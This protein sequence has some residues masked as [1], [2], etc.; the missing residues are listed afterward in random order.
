MTE[1]YPEAIRDFSTSADN[2]TVTNTITKYKDLVNRNQV[3]GNERNI[4]YWRK[5][6]WE[7]FSKFVD[8]K[9][10]QK[11]ITQIKRSKVPGKAIT[12]DETNKWLIVIPLD[13]DASCYHGRNTDWCTTKPNA[14]YFEKYFYDKNI[15]LI[16]FLQKETGKRWAIACHRKLDKIEMFD[17]RDNSINVDQ[18]QQQTGLDPMKYKDMALDK[19]HTP[20]YDQS[21]QQYVEALAIIQQATP[22]TKVDPQLEQ[23]LLF[24]KDMSSI[25]EYCAEVKGRWDV[26]ERLCIQNICSIVDYAK[27]VIKGRWPEAE[28]VVLEKGDL[29]SLVKYAVNVIKGRW[30]EAEPNIIAKLGNNWAEATSLAQ[31]PK[32]PA[33]NK[34]RE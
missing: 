18:F 2:S 33:S 20:K 27:D 11:S 30:P 10:Q 29:D 7:Q 31:N 25:V 8:T 13:K 22:F 6:G 9:S 21:K 12:L 14:S 15:V 4:D 5:Q 34:C 17:Q 19:Q 23:A 16:Y 24:A 3:Q 32:T 28:S 26:A 1:G